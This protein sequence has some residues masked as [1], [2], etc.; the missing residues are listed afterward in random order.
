[1]TDRLVSQLQIKSWL[2][3]SYSEDN[4]SRRKSVHIHTPVQGLVGSIINQPS[5]QYMCINYVS[6]VVFD[7][8]MT[9]DGRW[10][11]QTIFGRPGIARFLQLLEDGERLRVVAR[12]LYLPP[13]IIDGLWKSYQETG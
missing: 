7:C 13:S 10:S 9:H 3:D 4:A 8:W 11:C 12:R 2:N 5:G 6:C 1:M